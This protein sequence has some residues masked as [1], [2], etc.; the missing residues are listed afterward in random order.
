MGGD[1]REGREAAVVGR[2]G[3]GSKNRGIAIKD[4]RYLAI[5]LTRNFKMF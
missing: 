1:G 2:P 4:I 5:G 3:C